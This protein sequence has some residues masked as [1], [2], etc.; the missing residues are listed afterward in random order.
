MA[1]IASPKCNQHGIPPGAG[2]D[3]LGDGGKF[4]QWSIL[5]YDTCVYK[6]VSC[7]FRALVRGLENIISIAH[8]SL[9][10]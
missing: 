5:N 1:K 2:K 6:I 3:G 8:S 10:R 7:P 9:I 4:T